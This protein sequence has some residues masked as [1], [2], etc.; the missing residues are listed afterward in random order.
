M[1]CHW[2]LLPIDSSVSSTNALTS[3]GRKR[4][5][6]KLWVTRPLSPFSHARTLALAGRGVPWAEVSSFAY[7]NARGEEVRVP[8]IYI[9]KK[10]AIYNEGLAKRL[11]SRVHR[12]HTEN[13]V[14]CAELLV[15]VH[16][17]LRP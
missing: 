14:R 16:E 9:R 12:V 17:D 8:N 4:P 1:V 6:T 5:W 3:S 15:L 13:E 11:P 2:S 7:S 10:W